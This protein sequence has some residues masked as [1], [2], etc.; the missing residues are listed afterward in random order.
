MTSASTTQVTIVGAGISGLLISRHLIDQG[1][2]VTL[3]GPEDRREQTLCTW[4]NVQAPDYYDEHIAGRWRSWQF[5]ADNMTIVHQS[6]EY[7]YEALNGLSFKTSL[8]LSFDRLGA[9]MD[10]SVYQNEVR[11][12]ERLN[13]LYLFLN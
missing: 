12:I 8:E 4:R 2:S 10:L 3:V 11:T 1:A 5:G 9:L 13:F 6:D 7:W